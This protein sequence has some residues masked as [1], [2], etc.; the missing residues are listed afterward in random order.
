MGKQKYVPGLDIKLGPLVIEAS[1]D[2]SLQSDKTEATILCPCIHL[3]HSNFHIFFPYINVQYSVFYKKKKKNSS[4][5]GSLPKTS[6]N[7]NIRTP[8]II[9][10]Y[11]FEMFP[12]ISNSG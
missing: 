6:N 7:L 9:A 10:K 1:T 2:G 8:K 5:Y 12:K 11:N 3:S 4:Q